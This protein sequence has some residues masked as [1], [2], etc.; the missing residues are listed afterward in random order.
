VDAPEGQVPAPRRAALPRRRR[1]AE[2]TVL[3]FAV[4]GEDAPR[5]ADLSALLGDIDALRLTLQTDLSLAA[6]ALEEGAQD[7]A[8]ELVDGDLH[9]LRAFAARAGAR[10][11]ALDAAADETPLDEPA[12]DELP[13]AVPLRKRRI[14]SA[15]PLMAAAAALVGFVAFS[16]GRATSSPD[17]SMTSAAMAGYELSR[18]ASEGAPD[19]ALRDAAEE[20]N[21]ELAALIAQA[22]DDPA[23]A[24]QA[25][26]LLQTTTAVLEGQGDSGVLA[27]VMAETRALRERLRDALPTVT[28]RPTRP[29]RTLVREVPP[30]VPRVQ[31]EPQQ[32]RT[33]SSAPKSSAKPA[34]SPKPSPAATAAPA[35]T[36]PPASDP[37]P[38]PTQ[39]SG[40]LPGYDGLPGF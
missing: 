38:Q 27:G 26:M 1:A 32:E 5:V 33:S 23:A 11:D 25:L 14:L 19:E 3:P 12:L 7:L 2:P 35:P 8:A 30:V 16:P 13:V 17:T 22:A 34:A 24:Q 28:K 6:A 40:P 10:L 18:L 9:E 31:D 29:V 37:S 36:Q 39:P 21:D 15:A 20:L 4:P